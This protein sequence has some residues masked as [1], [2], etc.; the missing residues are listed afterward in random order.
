VYGLRGGQR[1]FAHCFGCQT[2]MPFDAAS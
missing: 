1:S 2:E